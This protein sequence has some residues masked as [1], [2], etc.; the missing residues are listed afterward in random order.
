LRVAHEGKALAEYPVIALE[1][2][3]AAGFFQRAWDGIA[4]WFK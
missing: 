1:N 3:A 2:I 4:L